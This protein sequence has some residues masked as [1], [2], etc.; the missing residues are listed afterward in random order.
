MKIP[1]DH[2][3]KHI[4]NEDLNPTKPKDH[5]LMKMLGGHPQS[6]CLAAGLLREK[7]LPELFKDFMKRKFQALDY[8]CTQNQLIPLEMLL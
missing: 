5:A 6:I 2:Q 3:L 4:I 8:G 1:P 7:M